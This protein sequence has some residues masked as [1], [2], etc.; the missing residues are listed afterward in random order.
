MTDNKGL[1]DL[2]QRNE[3]T[4]NDISQLQTTEKQLY[5]SLDDVKLSADQKQQIINK[6][7]EIAQIRLNLYS[8]LK[9]MYSYYQQ[10]VSSSR[11]T[12]SQQMTAIDIIE[13]ELNEAKK[14]LN[15]IESEKYDKLRL[16]EINTYYGKR[17]NAH[18]EVMKIIVYTC[19]P[20]II[21]ANLGTR[22][23]IPSNLY[24]LLM[25]IIIIVG[26]FFLGYKMIDL[27]NRSNMNWDEYNW[28]FNKTQAPTADTSNESN[29]WAMPYITC[30]GEQCC[31][32][33]SIY[34]QSKNMCVPNDVYA[35]DYPT[36]TTA[37]S[38]ATTTTTTATSTAPSTTSS[39]ATETFVSNVLSKYAMSGGA[40]VVRL[41]GNPVVPS[42]A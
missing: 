40:P 10:N 13:N 34:D 6:I 20:L 5:N 9:D 39:T 42:N 41:S 35:L 1:N 37:T 4:L 18:A 23:F 36:S 14:R 3:Q 27:S 7:N 11:S 24:I 15:L 21:L 12:L 22:G 31:Y 32:E 19:I 29:P 26:A 2:Q 33:G 28:Y 16:V 8:N 38:T 17:Y 25:C 30:I